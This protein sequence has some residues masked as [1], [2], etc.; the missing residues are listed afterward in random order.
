MSVLGMYYKEKICREQNLNENDVGIFLIV[1]CISQVTAVHQPE[2][3]YIN[4]QDGAISI[5]EIYKE[6]QEVMKV[7]QEDTNDMEIFPRGLTWAISGLAEDDIYDGNLKTLAV[8]GIH[9]IIKI[10]EKIENRQIELFDFIV[11][12]S[13]INGC[14][15]GVLNI[16]NPFIARSRVKDLV[17]RSSHKDFQDEMFMRMYQAGK[18]DVRPLEPRSIMSLDKDIKSSLDKMKRVQEI[19][20]QLPGIDCSA[21]GSPSC[22]ALAEDIASGKGKI[23]DCV[24]LLRDM[25]RKSKPRRR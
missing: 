4:L 5:Q 1:P 25:T 16:E 23:S 24:V 8:S 18:F 22:A 19:I 6:V 12:D 17:R 15:G 20:P 10:L 2:G 11:M 9:N 21:C 3:T 7:V 13:C 14:I